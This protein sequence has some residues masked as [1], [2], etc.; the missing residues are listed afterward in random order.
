M[1]LIVEKDIYRPYTKKTREYS[2]SYILRHFLINKNSRTQDYCIL[3]LSIEVTTRFELVIRELQSLA[4]PLGYVTI[5]NSNDSDG[6][7][8]RVT[9]VKGRCLDRLTTEP[10]I[11]SDFAVERPEQGSNLQHRG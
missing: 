11:N 10:Y 6:N 5:L 2:F 1:Q 9:A 4:L 7:R 3:E 8:T